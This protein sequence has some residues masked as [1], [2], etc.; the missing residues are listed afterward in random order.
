MIEAEKAQHGV[1]VFRACELLGVSRS[2]YHKWQTRPPSDRA[3]RELLAL[4][5]SDWAFLQTRG[6]AGD[7]PRE[8]ADGHYQSLQAALADDGAGDPT[9]RGLAPDLTGWQ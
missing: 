6:L 2:G 7:Y 8:R 5:A 9:L 1:P 3:L 4:Q